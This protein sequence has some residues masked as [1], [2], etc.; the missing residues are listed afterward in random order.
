MPGISFV[1]AAVFRPAGV[2]ERTKSESEAFEGLS[3]QAKPASDGQLSGGRLHRPELHRLLFDDY[4][5]PDHQTGAFATVA[6]RVF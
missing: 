6:V 1:C 5:R 2:P 4:P 3:G